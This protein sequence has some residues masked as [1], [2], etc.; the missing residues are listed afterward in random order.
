MAERESLLIWNAQSG[1]GA[2]SF[3][4]EQLSVTSNPA[5][6]PPFSQPPLPWLQP[7]LLPGRPCRR[8]VGD[9]PGP[10]SMPASGAGVGEVQLQ[11][12]LTR[13]MEKQPRENSSPGVVV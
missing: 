13:E 6:P 7:L 5:I 8:E 11:K 1:K 9:S 2:K 12:A 10:F 4:K 3:N